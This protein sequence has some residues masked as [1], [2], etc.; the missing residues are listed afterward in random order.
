MIIIAEHAA[1]PLALFDGCMG[2][3][4]RAARLQQAVF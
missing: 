3:A 4:Y 1:D 2:L